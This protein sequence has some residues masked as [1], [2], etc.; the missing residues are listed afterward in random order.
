MYKDTH[1]KM[2]AK[3]LEHESHVCLLESQLN[4]E[5]QS[6]VPLDPLA[7]SKVD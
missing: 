4:F 6:Q 3:L 7:I 1:L 5:L 2:K